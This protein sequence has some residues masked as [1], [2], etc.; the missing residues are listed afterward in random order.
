[1]WLYA[2]AICELNNLAWFREAAVFTGFGA[3][4]QVYPREGEF[5]II[6]VRCFVEPAT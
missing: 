3:P 1:M 6:L 4:S 2:I 5:P